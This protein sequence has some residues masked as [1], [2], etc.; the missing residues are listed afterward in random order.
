MSQLD[1]NLLTP[2]ERAIKIVGTQEDLAEEVG[3]SQPTVSSWVTSRRKIAPKHCRKIELL[4][5]GVVT[6]CQ[7]RPDIFGDVPEQSEAA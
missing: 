4:T 6:R 5:G 7:L 1:L 3:V 2:I